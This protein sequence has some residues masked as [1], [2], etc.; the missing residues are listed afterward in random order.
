VAQSSWVGVARLYAAVV[1][2][3]LADWIAIVVVLVSAT[4]GLRRG[5]VLSAFSLLGLAA[6][7][8]VGSRLAPHV[9]HGGSSSKWTPLAGLIGAV[10]GA[11]LLQFGALV[12][13]SFVRGGLRVAPLRAIDSAG[14]LLL[15][16]AIGLAIVW[17]GASAALL[18]PG[19]T[20]IRQEVE[21]SEIVKQLDTA[22]PPRTLLNLLARI[23]PFP[24]IVGPKAPSRPPSRGILRD[25]SIR[26]ATTRVV[27]V[28]GTACGVGVE[29]SGWFAGPS[30]IVTAAHV[31]AGES[32]TIVRIP[33]RPFPAPADVV[34]LDV[35]NDVAVLR[36]TGVSAVPLRFA[37][38]RPDAS[39]AIVGYPLDGGLT[40]T[41]GRIGLTATVLTQDALGHGPVARSITAVRG[42]VE[43]GDSGGPAVDKDG[44]VESAIFA[45]RLGSDSGYG[46]PPAI[47]R[48]DLAHAATHR[49]ST[50]ACAP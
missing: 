10:L 27:K 6:G 22:L 45:A 5:L 46:V 33:G 4:G 16:A 25:S 18:T 38:P 39:V 8:Y 29:G 43:H 30:L 47:M 24:S 23:D 14:G 37:D 42:K 13:G 34:L 9:L 36:I 19:R 21:R 32:D 28:L 41:P 3:N 2:L 20:A 26:A 1:G 49:V 11:M 7:A 48:S 31:V 40:A 44:R 17:V 12:A 50:G 15:G 35:H